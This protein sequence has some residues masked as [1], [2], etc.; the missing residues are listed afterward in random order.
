MSP[1]KLRLIGFLSLLFTLFSFSLS[2]VDFSL[3]FAENSFSSYGY[4]LPLILS[5]PN[6]TAKIHEV[7]NPDFQEKELDPFE[8]QYPH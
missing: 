8:G 4:I 7:I 5:S 6:V 3:Q 2:S 1:Q